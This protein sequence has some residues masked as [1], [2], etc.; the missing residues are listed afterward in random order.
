MLVW[1]VGGCGAG[2]GGGGVGVVAGSALMQLEVDRS[3]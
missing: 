3:G 1:D 2:V